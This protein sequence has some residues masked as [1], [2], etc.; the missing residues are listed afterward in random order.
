[1]SIISHPHLTTEWEKHTIFNILIHDQFS[2]KN[3][4][5]ANNKRNYLLIFGGEYFEQSLKVQRST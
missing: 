1:M 3:Q 2:L 4:N 5:E